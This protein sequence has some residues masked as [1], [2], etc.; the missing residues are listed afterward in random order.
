MLNKLK[1]ACAGVLISEI[2]QRRAPLGRQNDENCGLAWKIQAL[3]SFNISNYMFV[4]N[5]TLAALQ[6][7]QHELH[8]NTQIWN[9]DSGGGVTK[10]G[11]SVYGLFHR[12]ACTSQGRMCLRRLFLRPIMDIEIIQQRHATISVLLHEHNA[13]TVRQMTHCL[14]KIPNAR[15]FL[16]HLQKGIDNASVGTS[17]EKGAWTRCESFTANTARLYDLVHALCGMETS[18]ILTTVRSLDSN[19]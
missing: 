12:F 3:E 5:E 2:Q 10:E 6:I 7:I 1:L 13:E 4:S 18:S 11:L 17:F 14:R 8:P 16:P 15:R 9:Q 19:T